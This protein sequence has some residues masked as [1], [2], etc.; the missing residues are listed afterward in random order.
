M[1]YT[2]RRILYVTLLIKHL[3]PLTTTELEVSHGNV[4]MCECSEGSDGHGSITVD[5]TQPNSKWTQPNQ[6]NDFLNWRDPTQ[7]KPTHIPDRTP[8]GYC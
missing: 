8:Q 2:N 1:R 3:A 5:S 4:A 7:P 6:T